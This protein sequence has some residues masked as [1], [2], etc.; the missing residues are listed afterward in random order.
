[1]SGRKIGEELWC[2]F[3]GEFLEHSQR[4]RGTAVAEMDQPKIQGAEAPLGQD[5]D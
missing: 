5:F 2:Q 3:D 4:A 1:M